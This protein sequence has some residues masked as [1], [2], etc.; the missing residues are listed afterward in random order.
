[1]EFEY[2]KDKKEFRRTRRYFKFSP[3]KKEVCLILE[4]DLD[5]PSEMKLSLS[6]VTD[7]IRQILKSDEFKTPIKTFDDWESEKS[8]TSEASIEVKEP[9]K[10]EYAQKGKKKAKYAPDFKFRVV[11]AVD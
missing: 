10:K 1:M 7:K 9:Q 11:D 8:I 6:N 3:N 5:D 4:K 2:L